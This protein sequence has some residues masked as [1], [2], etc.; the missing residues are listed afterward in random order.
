V[1][2]KTSKKETIIQSAEQHFAKHGYELTRLEDIAKECHIT[3]P[4]IYYHFKDKV[5]LYE[6]VLLH[7]FARLTKHIEDGTQENDPIENLR[8]Y[9]H[10]F[11]QYV[12]EHPSFAYIFSREISNDAQFMPESCIVELSKTLNRLDAILRAGE[13]E[14]IFHC[15]NPFMLQIMIVGTLTSYM[16]TQN[17]RQRVS[18]VLTHTHKNVDPKVEDISTKLTE[19]IIKALTC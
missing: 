15:E 17:L 19:K 10:L 3:K 1:S 6:S 8:E 12:L 2:Q 9:I 7:S 13:Q 16:T 14:G 18:S 11:S 4:A 5:T